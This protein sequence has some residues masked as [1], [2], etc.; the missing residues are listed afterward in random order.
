VLDEAA[1]DPDSDSPGAAVEL[2]EAALLAEAVGLADGSADASS[3][4]SEAALSTSPSMTGSR[5]R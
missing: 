4:A 3:G 2:E 5:S 1:L